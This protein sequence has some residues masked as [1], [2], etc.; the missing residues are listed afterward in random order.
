M[1]SSVLRSERAVRVN[2]EIM[3]AFVRVR[4]LL[5]AHAELVQRLDEL[6]QRYD[7]QFRA[8]FEAIRELMA[9]P[10][11]PRKQIGFQVREPRGVYCVGKRTNKTKKV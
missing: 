4:T 5:A 10:D 9:P 3:R 8:V 11:P 1:L 7:A 6:E 2:I